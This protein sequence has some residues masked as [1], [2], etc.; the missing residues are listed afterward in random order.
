MPRKVRIPASRPGAR[1]SSRARRFERRCPVSNRKQRRRRR[2]RRPDLA[3]SPGSAPPAAS[4][5]GQATLRLLACDAS[6]CE[7][8]QIVRP[9]ELTTARER[10]PVVWIDVEG[11]DDPAT[12][13][14]IGSVFDIG[15]LALEDAVTP[16]ERPK[17][18]VFGH[19]VLIAARS[20]RYESETIVTDPVCIFLGDRYV[21][22]FRERQAA[23]P[24]ESVRHRIRHG[25]TRIGHEGADAL[26]ALLLDVLIDGAFPVLEQFGDRLETLEE[27]A[28]DRPSRQSLV[29]IHDVRNDLM[30][31][32]RALWP[33]RDLLHALGRE[34]TPLVGDHA[35]AHFRDS[36]DHVMELLDLMEGYR[37]ISSDL[38]DIY[39]ASLNNR[40]NDVMK[41]LTVIATIFMPLTFITGY[42][43]MNFDTSSPWNMPLLRYRYGAAVAI[44][45]MAATTIG[46]V[47]FFWRRGWLRRWH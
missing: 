6:T 45:M 19:Q 38:R 8:S 15:E 44:G 42:Y 33:T 25:R 31:L 18:E 7:E 35:R 11:I 16:D 41:V 14:L 13:R 5:D 24:F 12:T 23:D 47:A 3:A 20:V 30:T 37:E 40:M 22:T 36:Y 34:P 17:V 32:R 4:G 29:G 9:E 27:E 10:W 28:I 2:H 21:L 43:G 26:C 39:L 46:M 1:P